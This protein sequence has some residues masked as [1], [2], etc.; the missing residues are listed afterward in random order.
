MQLYVHKRSLSGPMHNEQ[1]LFSFY[2]E[3]MINS[4]HHIGPNLQA[5]RISIQ[6]S[7]LSLNSLMILCRFILPICS[8]S[9]CTLLLVIVSS[10]FCCRFLSNKDIQYQYTIIIKALQACN[11]PRHWIFSMQRKSF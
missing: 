7:C 10:F 1:S 4:Y 9:D 8:A 11:I 5:G 2:K 3:A 6:W